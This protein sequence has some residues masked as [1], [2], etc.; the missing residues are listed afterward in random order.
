LVAS[1]Q[2]FGNAGKYNKPTSYTQV[3]GPD[4]KAILENKITPIQSISE[5]T[6][7]VMNKLMQT[8]VEVLT[9]QDVLQSFLQSCLLVKQ[10]LLRIGVTCFC[11]LHS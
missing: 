3:I 5:D 8:V 6:A 1:Y 9:E 11:W 7:Y 10:V 4:G 2:V